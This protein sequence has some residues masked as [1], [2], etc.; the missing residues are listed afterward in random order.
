M[1]RSRGGHPPR[2]SRPLSKEPDI[3]DVGGELTRPGTNAIS[4]TKNCAAVL[5][6]SRALWPTG[7]PS[8]STI[9]APLA[10]K[11]VVEAGATIVNDVPGGKAEPEILD[12][13]ADA[14]VD[15]FSCTGAVNPPLM[16]FVD[17]RRRAVPTP[18]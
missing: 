2:L 5:P 17:W 8:P 15:T 4:S 1:G 10:A 3:I 7:R 16:N 6:V 11:A 12:V 18:T 13:V 14:G 9:C